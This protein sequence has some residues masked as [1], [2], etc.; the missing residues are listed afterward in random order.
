M[1]G[2]GFLNIWYVAKPDYSVMIEQK[3]PLGSYLTDESGMK[4]YYF[5]KDSAGT[6][7]CTRDCNSTWL[8][9]NA[10]PLVLPSLLKNSDF[11]TVSWADGMKQIAFMGRPLYYYVNDINPGDTAGQGFNNLWYVANVSGVVP[12]STTPATTATMASA[13]T[14]TTVTMITPTTTPTTISSSGGGSSGGY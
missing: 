14:M 10:D 1:K 13:T 3:D 7:A 2:E 4:L 9:F 6:S 11:S 5:Q 12:T 8:P